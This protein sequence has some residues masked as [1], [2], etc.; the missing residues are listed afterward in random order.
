MTLFSTTA[1]TVAMLSGLVALSGCATAPRGAV[2]SLQGG[3]YQSVVKSSDRAS[4]SK[5]M[6]GDAK[7]TCGGGMFSKGGKYAVISQT[8]KEKDGKEIRTDNKTTDAGIALG[9]RYMGLESKDAVELTT[10]FKCE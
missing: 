3:Q 4:A 1:A 9:L 10:V 6:D 8:I 5:V 2:L 7:I